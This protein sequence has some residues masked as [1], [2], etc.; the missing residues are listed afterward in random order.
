MA[1]GTVVIVSNVGGNIELIEN[2]INGIIKDPNDSN[3]F[4]EEIIALFDN[5]EL[6]QSLESQA[7]NTVKKYD[8]NQVG[9]L[10]LNIYE[11]VLDKSK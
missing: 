6:R 2:G 10:Y 11:S 8:W 1:C 3:S 7:Q 4:V 5:T 9:N